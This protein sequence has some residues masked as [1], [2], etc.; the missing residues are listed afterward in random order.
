MCRVFGA[1]SSGDYMWRN[2]EES[3]KD[4]EDQHLED[5]IRVLHAESFGAYGIRRIVRNLR[6]QGIIINPKRIRR[7]IRTIGV[8]GKGTQ[9]VML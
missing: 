5:L 9:S 1:S 3:A 7:V 6:H 4:T 2:S 8:K